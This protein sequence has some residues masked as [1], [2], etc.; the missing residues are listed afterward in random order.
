MDAL[1]RYLLFRI[2][3][4]IL[5]IEL[6]IMVVCVIGIILIKNITRWRT[7]RTE[8]LQNK[9][10]NIIEAKLFNEEKLDL[11]IP[12]HLLDF[13]NV[14]EVLEKFDQLFNDSRWL[15]LKEKVI[16]QYLIQ[17]AQRYATNRSWF[18]RQLAA[19]CYF[20]CPKKASEEILG[21]L[22]NDPKYLVR[23]VAAVCIT[24]TPHKD[25][26]YK[27]L[28]K[29][30][31]ETALSQFP[32]RDAL[33][34]IDQE[35][36]LWLESILAKE[37]NPA[38]IAICLDVLSTRYSGN[39]LP[40]IRPFLNAENRECRILSIKALGNIPSS[41]TVDLLTSH[42]VDS[43]WEVRTEV[44]QGLYKLHAVQTIPQLKS[45]LNDPIWWVRLQCALTLKNF[46]KEGLEILHAQDKVREPMGYEI[47]QYALALPD[48]IYRTV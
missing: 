23:V 24:K 18:K 7:R 39:L 41:E 47:A 46:G 34:Q 40:L 10:S 11:S 19:R 38:L 42:L 35:K 36:F 22:L 16:D 33:V 20:L 6:L 43:D 31:Q 15:E 45:L 28:V 17:Q 37:T 44:I 2:T 12:P 4:K 8:R 13:R 5:L 25:L 14:V 26:F 9:L 48:Q 30:S 32:Y 3:W 27:M 29:M 21:K 1:I